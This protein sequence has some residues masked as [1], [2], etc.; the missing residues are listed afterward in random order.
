[1]LA[2]SVRR[3]STIGRVAI[4]FIFVFLV[5]FVPTAA[6]AEISPDFPYESKYIEV[7][8]SKM[9]YVESGQ[10]DQIL[11]LHGNPTWSYIWRN[12]IPALSSKGRVIAVDLIGF[13]KSD[14]PDLEY[15]VEDHSK[16]LEEFIQKMKLRNITLVVHDWGSVL[17][18]HYAR[19]HEANIRGLVFFE[20]LLLPLP[21]MELWPDD[22]RRLFEDLRTPELGW[23]LAVHQNVF[24]EKR[25][26]QGIMRKLT[27]QEMENYRDPF[28][29]AES[30]KPIWRFPNE[31]PI[32]GQPADVSKMQEEYLA[33]LQQT[34]LP[35]L[36]LF[37]EPG[38]LIPIAAV[39]WARAHLK[40]LTSVHI[41]KGIH[42]IQE[43]R[44]AEIGRSIASWIDHNLK[45]SWPHAPGI[46]YVVNESTL[47]LNCTGKG[48]TTV[49]LG[50]GVGQWSIHWY[51]VQK[52]L[53]KEMRVCSY[54]RAGYGW[55]Y[56]VPPAPSAEHAAQEL[57]KL[58]AVSGERGPF[59]FAG[60][61]YAGYVIRL[62][63]SLFPNDS[64][65]LIFI[66][67]A[68]EDQWDLL[69]ATKDLI[70]EG[71]ASLEQVITEIRAGSF[72]QKPAVDERLPQEIGKALQAVMSDPAM[73]ETMLAES[74]AAFESA[75]QV[76]KSRLP[77]GIP[78]VVLSAGNSFAWFYEPKEE[79]A[80]ILKSLNDG[81]AQLQN[82]LASLS[83]KNKHLIVK[84]ATHNIVAE[85]P[86]ETAN[87]IR[88]ALTLMGVE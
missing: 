86:D 4:F 84:D 24:I 19:R 20:A 78:I 83:P 17:G 13:G 60:H 74:R 10:G 40:N 34:E 22:A 12:I 42:N 7:F 15:R 55:S 54:D 38:S 59:V 45:L 28:K 81:W 49:I 65:A 46:L 33:W 56:P 41:G 8:D 80:K 70:Q 88:E 35:K 68:H 27:D 66:D 72:Q 1:M 39:E 44:P 79:N 3:V 18:F 77:P 52:L 69:P 85:R 53:E 23:N 31:L 58:L 76:A 47:H 67:A 21:R 36:L 82:S 14:K 26:Q 87:A 43:D 25:L 51:S 29:N 16:Y 50:S 75:K 57:H 30:R 2:I 73:Y 71:I 6:S 9:H 61:S 37:A 32:D 63:A 5:A 11:L 48:A 64:A 62:F